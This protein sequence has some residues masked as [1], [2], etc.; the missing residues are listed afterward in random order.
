MIPRSDTDTH[1][2]G[3]F[4]IALAATIVVHVVFVPR[5]FPGEFTRGLPYL[6]VGWG[7]YTLIFYT[8]G[9]LRPVDDRM[10]NMR[11][12]D[13][14]LGVFLSSIVLSGL[15]DAAGLTLAGTPLVHALPAAGVYIGLGLAGWG[16]GVRTRTVNRIT[17]GDG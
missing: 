11:A 17:A 2:V 13:L 4:L 3:I 8:L 9:R 6:V 14:G 1:L 16:F 15:L 12:I 10:P 5:Y 7:S